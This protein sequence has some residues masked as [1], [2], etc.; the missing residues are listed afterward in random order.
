[1]RD[2]Y[3]DGVDALLDLVSA[4]PE[5]LNAHAALVRDGGRVAS[6]V[7]AAGEG[8]GR[9]NLVAIPTPENLDRLAA[10]LDETLSVPI[11]A[12]YPLSRADEAIE[13]LTTQHTQGKLSI[14][15]P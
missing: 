2:L 12:T 7:G 13:V 4:A 6:S 10:L 3:P 8:L 5:A 9:S 1:V 11:Q 15:V 14:T